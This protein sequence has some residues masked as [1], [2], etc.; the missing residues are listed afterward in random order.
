MTYTKSSTISRFERFI[1]E[2]LGDQYVISIYQSNYSW[3]RDKQIKQLLFDIENVFKGETKKYFNGEHI[4]EY[5]PP[6][7]IN[8]E[9]WLNDTEKELFETVKLDEFSFLLDVYKMRPG[10]QRVEDRIK[11]DVANKINKLSENGY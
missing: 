9:E 10:F 4:L 8:I 5:D 1:K 2:A 7:S 11:K 6:L 3:K